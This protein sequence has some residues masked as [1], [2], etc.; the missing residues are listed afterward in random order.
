MKLPICCANSQ[1]TLKA[2]QNTFKVSRTFLIKPQIIIC[3]DHNGCKMRDDFFSAILH[4][5]QLKRN[6]KQK[7]ISEHYLYVFIF[8]LR[9]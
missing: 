2:Y 7:I 8:K 5:F 1:G 4:C 6:E 9:P 3:P